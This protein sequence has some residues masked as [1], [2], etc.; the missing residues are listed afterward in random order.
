MAARHGGAECA[1]GART[2]T[3]MATGVATGVATTGLLST[4][5]FSFSRNTKLA[6]SPGFVRFSRW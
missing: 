1:P 2:G 6:R 4:F 3:G 5:A